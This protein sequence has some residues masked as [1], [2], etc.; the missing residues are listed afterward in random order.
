MCHRPFLPSFV[1]SEEEGKKG[2]GGKKKGKKRGLAAPLT[3]SS[4]SLLIC[5]V[6]HRLKRKEG[7]K[8][9]RKLAGISLAC[10]WQVDRGELLG[11]K[12]ESKRER[13]RR[14]RR[15]AG[16]GDSLSTSTPRQEKKEVRGRPATVWSF[17]H[18]DEM[19]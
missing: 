1:R 13:K 12:K 17:D 11:R 6:T 16:A 15:V 18:D 14:R 4:F 3:F 2:G 7:R 10:S 19:R 9:H 5:R 8:A